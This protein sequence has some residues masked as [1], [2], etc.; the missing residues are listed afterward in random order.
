LSG[1]WWGGGEGATCQGCWVRGGRYKFVRGAGAWGKPVV[2]SF[3]MEGKVAGYQG[4]VGMPVVKG[5]MLRMRST[6]I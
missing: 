1:G 5:F 6:I 3:L 2:R 4:F